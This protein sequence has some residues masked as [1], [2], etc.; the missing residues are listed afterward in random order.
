MKDFNYYRNGKVLHP[1][2]SDYVKFFVYKEGKLVYET[3][4]GELVPPEY[5]NYT[6][7]KKTDNKAFSEHVVEYHEEQQRLFELFK[8]DLFKDLGIENNPKREML[9][10]KACSVSSDSFSD[11]YNNARELVDLIII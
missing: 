2:L 6:T 9:F 7:E 11:I 3:A 1:T 5:R 4:Y 8:Q 10:D